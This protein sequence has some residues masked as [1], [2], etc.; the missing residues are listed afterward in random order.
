MNECIFRKPC[1]NGTL[2]M[3]I[4]KSSTIAP[5]MIKMLLLLLP[6][7]SALFVIMPLFVF[8]R[9]TIIHIYS[10]FHHKS[11]KH[12]LYKTCPIWFYSHLIY[13]VYFMVALF[14]FLLSDFLSFVHFQ[15]V[16]SS[17]HV[18]VH[19]IFSISSTALQ[20]HESKFLH[21]RSFSV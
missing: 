12:R 10:L 3:Y 9:N 7:P 8:Q 19:T 16:C 15:S 2:W 13:S 20:I 1:V 21:F 11:H 5:T 6:L 17:L 14:L 4:I 18:H